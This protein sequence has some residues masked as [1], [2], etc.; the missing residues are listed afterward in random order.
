[1][2]F[3]PITTNTKTISGESVSFRNAKQ[4]ILALG[5]SDSVRSESGTYELVRRGKF[6]FIKQAWHGGPDG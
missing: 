4:I 2:R 1:M 6:I 3:T 5:T